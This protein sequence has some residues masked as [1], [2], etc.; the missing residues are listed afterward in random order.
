[1]SDKHKKL[2]LNII[3]RKAS[4]EYAFLHKYTAGI[5]LSGTEVKSVKAGN[6]NIGEAYCVFE[7]DGLYVKNMHISE[8]QYGGHYNHDPLRSRKLLLKKS[9]LE[10]IKERIREKGITL[11]PVKMF[12]SERG[13]I[14]VEIAVAKG[15]KDYDKRESNK[16]RDVERQLRRKEY[17]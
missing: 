10:K 12:L 5:Q 4:F 14:K 6:V 15:K 3:N 7:S 11:V 1:M 16:E 2:H 17:D 9:E 8:F 13:Y